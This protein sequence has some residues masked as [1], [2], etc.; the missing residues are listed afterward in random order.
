MTDW[1]KFFKVEKANMWQITQVETLLMGANLSPKELE[2]F[3]LDLTKEEADEAIE[4][5]QK[6]QIDRLEAGLDYSQ[7]DIKRKLKQL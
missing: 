1:F 4:Y 6:N 3:S 7:R 2:L 5:L